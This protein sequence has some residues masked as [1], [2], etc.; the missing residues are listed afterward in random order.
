MKFLRYVP[1][2]SSNACN[3]NINQ[4]H[5]DNHD[6]IFIAHTHLFSSDDNHSSSIR[7]KQSQFISS[8][9]DPLQLQK[10]EQSKQWQKRHTEEIRTKIESPEIQQKTK[11]MIK[12][13]AEDKSTSQVYNIYDS[14]KNMNQ[15]VLTDNNDNNK[16]QQTQKDL[17]S[18]F[19]SSQ[20][21]QD[22]RNFL[23]NKIPLQI[24]FSMVPEDAPEVFDINWGDL[25]PPSTL[26]LI[27]HGICVPNAELVDLQ[28]K[29]QYLYQLDMKA[30]IAQ[31][32]QQQVNKSRNISHFSNSLQMVPEDSPDNIKSSLKQ[33][34]SN[35]LNENEIQFDIENYETED[36]DNNNDDQ[37]QEDKNDDG[38][39]GDD[40][41][42]IY[43]YDY[44]QIDESEDDGD[45]DDDAQIDNY[46]DEQKE[47]ENDEEEEED[48]DDDYDDEIVKI[49]IK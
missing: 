4:S 48:D 33:S 20:P 1:E 25:G 42:Q 32:S 38:D 41:A 26:G 29:Q 9:S 16:E 46:D 28:E 35:S 45:S 30:Q 23:S 36:D 43:D 19:S 8:S 47:D 27:S 3:S 13:I 14:Q 17:N 21:L 22:Y 7:K 6:N 5:N 10:D 31:I 49:L 15:I 34:S 40:Y 39:V 18:I 12:Q 44:T 24:G 11:Q 37:Q 2:I